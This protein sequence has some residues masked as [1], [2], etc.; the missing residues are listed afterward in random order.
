MF[1]TLHGSNIKIL[2]PRGSYYISLVTK[3]L[4]GANVSNIEAISKIYLLRAKL[5]VY[6]RQANAKRLVNTHTLRVFA[7][8]SKYLKNIKKI[9]PLFQ[10]YYPIIFSIFFY[11]IEAIS[12]IY[13]L[14]A[15]L[16]V[17]GR[18]ANAKRLV[19]TQPLWVFAISSICQKN[20]S[21]YWID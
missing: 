21:V 5:A 17:Y 6:G 3:I 1:A 4:F 18:Q 2:S 12:K 9:F 11:P 14:R 13:L 19:N 20:I 8:S 10:L 7:I 15:K 16:A